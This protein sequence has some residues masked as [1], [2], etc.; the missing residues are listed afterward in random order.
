[1][2]SEYKIGRKFKIQTSDGF[3]YQDTP[4]QKV[5]N[6]NHLIKINKFTKYLEIGVDDPAGNFHQ[7]VCEHKHSVDP[8]VEFETDDVD[9]K[10]TS[11]DFFELLDNNKLDLPK[12]YKWDVVFVDGL[13]ISDQVERDINNALNHL[14]PNGFI[15][16]HDANPPSIHHAREDYYLAN[17]VRAPWNGTVW[18][19]IYK[20]NA[21]R[22][23]LIIHTVV[24]L[25]EDANDND[26]GWGLTVISRGEQ[27][28]C[29]FDNSFYEYRTFE[30]N[31]AKHLNLI[32]I[33]DFFNIYK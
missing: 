7:V 8:C 25:G 29:D 2:K 1:M 24:P 3:I 18:K 28:C 27:E 4:V 14:S 32:G 21:T 16:V 13:H 23:D 11:D 20:L 9:F 26:T 15:L 19:C 33:S 30:K 12:D 10:N 22:K 17:G 31:R 6:I 5:H